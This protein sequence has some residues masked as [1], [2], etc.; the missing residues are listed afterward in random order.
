MSA[1]HT[2]CKPSDKSRHYDPE[3]CVDERAELKLRIQELQKVDP[4]QKYLALWQR[5]LRE[6]G[7][8]PNLRNIL[9]LVRIVLVIPVQTA[10]LERGFSL[11]KRVKND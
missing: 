8:N 9:G 1:C 5:I 2:L 4:K 11:M 6:S 3:V 10:S 7:D